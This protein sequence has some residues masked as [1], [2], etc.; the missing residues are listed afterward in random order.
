ML[1]HIKQTHAPADCPYGRGGSRSLFDGDH[2]GVKIHGYWLA[3][4]QHTTFLVVETDDVG[5]LQEFLKPG[6]GVAMAE[7]TPVSDRPVAPSS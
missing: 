3:F 6:A 2:P 7:I 5:H 4:P 1:F